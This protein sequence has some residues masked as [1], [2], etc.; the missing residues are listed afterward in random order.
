MVAAE[1]SLQIDT[2]GNIIGKYPGKFP[3]APALATGSHIDTVPNGGRF[4]G[5]FG[6]LA[7]VEV[8]RVLKERQIQQP[9]A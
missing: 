1:M 9:S 4:D 3:Q 2:A 8:V 5:A 6:V 7:G